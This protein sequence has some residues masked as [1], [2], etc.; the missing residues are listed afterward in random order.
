MSEVITGRIITERPRAELE[1]PGAAQEALFWL[2]DV[3]G[4]VAPRHPVNR[5]LGPRRYRLE[6]L[7]ELCDRPT[8]N[9]VASWLGSEAVPAVKSK[10]AYADDLRLWA[11]VARELGGHDRFFVGSVTPGMIET[12]T[13]QQKARGRAPRS[14]NRRLSVLTALTEYAKWKTKDQSMVSPVTKHD[15]PKVDPRDETTATP[16]L[17]VAEFQAVVDAA[18]TPRQALVPVLIYTLAGR[19]TECCT[20]QLADLKA[21]GGERKLD[22]RRKGGKGRVFALPDRLCDLIDV[23]TAD[24][25]GQGAL[26]LDDEGRPMDRHAVDRLLTRLG[27]AAKVLPDRDL[28]PHVLRASKL[29]HMHD[30]GTPVEEIQEYADHAAI[31]TTLRYIRRRNTDALKARHATAAVAVYDHLVDKFVTRSGEAQE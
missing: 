19:V 22:L 13:K 7:A 21:I 29:T 8:F 31:E 15:R 12:W 30:A 6:L 10:Q 25:D 26:L 5:R 2:R 16:I 14:I 24:R 4:T 17:E 27:R 23:A 28:T 20:A 3:L 18:T 1:A 9:L 11:E